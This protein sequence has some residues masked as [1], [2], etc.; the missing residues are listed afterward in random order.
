MYL[1]NGEIRGKS[2]LEKNLIRKIEILMYM[3]TKTAYLAL[4]LA[5]QEICK[6]MTLLDAKEHVTAPLIRLN[7][8]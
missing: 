4:R 7:E 3:I 1:A 8:T 5:V 6:I 2:D